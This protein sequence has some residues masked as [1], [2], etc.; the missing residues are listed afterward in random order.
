[1][2]LSHATA[3]TPASSTPVSACV[4]ARGDACVLAPCNLLVAAA[5]PCSRLMV[6]K[7]ASRM[8]TAG[9]RYA[10]CAAVWCPVH[11]MYL[12]RCQAASSSS[13]RL[14]AMVIV[15]VRELLH[16]QCSH[17]P[18]VQRK[19]CAAYEAGVEAARG[20]PAA[21]GVRV[22]PRREQPRCGGRQPRPLQ[23]RGA[24]GL[25]GPCHSS[26]LCCLIPRAA[27]DAGTE[28]RIDTDM[29]NH[30]EQVNLE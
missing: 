14:P 25:A 3:S 23:P 6:S 30:V 12:A 26:A 13:C 21:D 18:A 20:A 28:A 15:Q 29:H 9:S 4:A 24:H 7:A 5:G 17:K 27:T 19:A 22:I 10:G 2:L 1:M 11:S 16:L 8:T